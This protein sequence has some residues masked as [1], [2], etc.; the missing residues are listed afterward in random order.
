M[1]DWAGKVTIHHLPSHS[2]RLPE[3]YKYSIR[4]KEKFPQVVKLFIPLLATKKPPFKPG[5]KAVFSN[6]GYLALEAI[7]EEAAGIFLEKFYQEE[8]FDK[9]GMKNSFAVIPRYRDTV[10]NSKLEKANIPEKYDA[11]TRIEEPEKIVIRKI[12]ANHRASAPKPLDV[13]IYSTVEDLNKWQYALHNGQI[14]LQESYEK[15]IKPYY[16]I[17]SGNEN[18]VSQI[19]YGMKISRHLGKVRFYDHEADYN[20]VRTQIA[21]V[22]EKSIHIFA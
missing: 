2:H 16:S 15:M 21:Y 17:E 10:I 11:T 4:R 5:K 3:M 13:G 19:G 18:V 9:L 22:P 14:L 12:N 20:G 7:L 6:T 8:F 1:P